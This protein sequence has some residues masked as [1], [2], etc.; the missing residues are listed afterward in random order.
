MPTPASGLPTSELDA[1]TAILGRMI[2]ILNGKLSSTQRQKLAGAMPS[3]QWEFPDVDTKLC[4]AAG[5]DAL[6]VAA[7]LDQPPFVVRMQRSTLED[8]AFARRSLGAA[9]LAGRIH[10]RGMNPLRLR[11]F[12]MLV[13]PLLESYREA[14]LECSAA[15][16]APVS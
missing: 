13:D 6:C 11:E 16:S 14:Y 2:S 5:P 7:P 9:F 15:P 1:F 3:I 4:L 12:I 10:V 8:A